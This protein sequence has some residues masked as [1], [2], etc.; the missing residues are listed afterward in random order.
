MERD[1]PHEVPVVRK[2]TNDLFTAG[3]AIYVGLTRAPQEAG[4][5]RPGTPETKWG[6]GAHAFRCVTK[7]KDVFIVG[8]QGQA[9]R[10]RH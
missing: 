4:F 9:T 10:D 6:V 3:S 5:V 2:G 8:A 1:W 7:G